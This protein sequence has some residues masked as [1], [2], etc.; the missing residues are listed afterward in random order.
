MVPLF[1]LAARSSC[2][3]GDCS[4]KTPFPVHSCPLWEV[5]IAVYFLSWNAPKALFSLTLCG[6]AIAGTEAGRGT[7]PDFSAGRQCSG[8][9]GLSAQPQAA[10]EGC[11]WWWQ[12]A[13]SSGP[14]PL[15]A[16]QTLSCPIAV[17]LCAGDT[18]VLCS[19]KM[20]LSSGSLYLVTSRKVVSLFSAEP[21]SLQ[22][23]SYSHSTSL[24]VWWPAE[25]G[26]KS[27]Q[28]SSELVWL[29]HGLES[30]ALSTEI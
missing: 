9:M 4:V 7:E 21:R 20:A 15:P 8:Q 23:G 2:F 27:L 14:A 3:W 19:E 26:T 29:L 16:A 30:S 22:M 10:T 11:S 13:A 24:G 17:P 1:E 25:R 28:T 12:L 5:W 6:S 18:G